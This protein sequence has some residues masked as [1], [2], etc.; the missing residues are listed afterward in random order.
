VV[1]TA[2]ISSAGEIKLGTTNSNSTLLQLASTAS[3]S[4]TN[5]TWNP[6][7]LTT[8]DISTYLGLYHFF[9]LLWINQLIQAISMCTVAGVVNKYYWV[10]DRTVKHPYGP[11]PIISSLW[12]ALRYHF[13]SLCFG[14][15]IIAIVQF[16]RACLAY[17]DNKTKN[18]QQSNILIKIFMKAVQCCMCLLEK[19]LKYIAKSAYIMIAMKGHS[20]CHA[21]KEAVGLLYDNMSQIALSNTIV[22]FMLLL[23]KFVISGVCGVLFYVFI[24]SNKD[25]APGGAKELSAPVVPLVLTFCLAYFVAATFMGVYGMVV[26]TILLLFCVDKKE[27]KEADDG[28]FM[29]N[30]LA[31]LLGESKAKLKAKKEGAEGK[32][33]DSSSSDSSD[34]EGEGCDEEPVS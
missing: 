31:R 1:I 16:I 30:E 8:S 5:S 11:R 19:C 33:D 27:N 34:S 23:A 4:V 17:L 7:A 6:Q 24:D 15:L 26:D 29:S 32:K 22:S 13:G 10:R 18:L 28:Y 21:T 12:I 14:S 3:G 2:Y 25:Y 9:G 20:F